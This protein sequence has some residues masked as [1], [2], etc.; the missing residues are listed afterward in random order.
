MGAMQVLVGMKSQHSPP[1]VHGKG[2]GCDKRLPDLKDF[3]DSITVKG[4]TLSNTVIQGR[5][6]ER[7]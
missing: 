4:D 2:T 7:Y 3:R 1:P 5:N 6:E